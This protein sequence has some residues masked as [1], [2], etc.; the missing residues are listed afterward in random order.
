LLLSLFVLT[1]SGTV[2][3]SNNDS[4]ILNKSIPLEAQL[5]LP[6]KKYV[7]KDKYDLN[8]DTLIIPSSSE[9]IFKRGQIINGHISFDKTT[10]TAK[11]R[12]LFRGVTASG[13]VLAP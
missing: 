2:E 13:T 6:N 3:R 1:S 12:V 4:I 8:G 9:L 7:V 5:I 10:I 11:E